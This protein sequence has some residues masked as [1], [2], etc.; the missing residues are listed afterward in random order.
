MGRASASTRSL[1]HLAQLF[2]E[3]L[4]PR[5]LNLSW[6]AGRLTYGAGDGCLLRQWQAYVMIEGVALLC[7]HGKDGL[8]EKTGLGIFTRTQDEENQDAV[9]RPC[10]C[11][12]SSTLRKRI[13]SVMR[14]VP[15]AHLLTKVGLVPDNLP[16][17]FAGQGPTLHLHNV[18]LLPFSLPRSDKCSIAVG[19]GQS[20]EEGGSLRRCIERLL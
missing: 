20:G 14:K 18:P 10:T 8:A 19:A 17:I 15:D 12:Y 13:S 5:R 2:L 9:A 6:H 1:F 3:R 4:S 11:S 16:Q 7:R